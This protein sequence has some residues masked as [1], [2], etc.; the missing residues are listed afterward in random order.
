MKNCKKLFSSVLLVSFGALFMNDAYAYDNEVGKS[1]STYYWKI[2]GTQAG[3]SS[4][5]TTAINSCMGSNREVHVVTGG[6][7]NGTIVVPATNVKLYCHDNTFTRDFSGWGIK[8]RH[9]GFQVHDMILRGG[10]NGYGIRSDGGSHIKMI[11]VQIYDCPWIGIRVDSKENNPWEAWVTDLEIQ[12]VRVEDCGDQGIETYSI[13][14][15]VMDS[16]VV[17]NCTSCGVL[18]NLT[19]NGTIGTVNAY[20]CA[21]GSGYA[22]LRYA[23][24]C[25]NITTDK[26]IADH[27]GRG[28]FIVK[29]G[30][31]VNCHL[32][33]AEIYEC[34]DLGIW[35]E[36]GTNC[37]VKA[38]CCESPVSVSG[39]G[40]SVNVSRD[41]DRVGVTCSRFFYRSLSQSDDYSVYSID[42][43]FM[44]TIRFDRDKTDDQ[45]LSLPSGIYFIKS[46]RSSGS[47][48]IV[49]GS[50]R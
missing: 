2:N 5:L 46:R 33:N 20:N 37:S 17:R 44:P 45:Y 28:F 10:T 24:E 3:T 39:P 13:D 29:S 38:G 4:S 15:V 14:G 27:C 41:C 32:N 12:N 30:P 23:N 18:F 47:R 6:S 11:N 50:Y 42:G 25:T 16:I 9:D 8:N 31:S 7:L 40:S 34:S 19:K 49:V 1:G 36:N 26:L 22:G 35:I 43:K 21:W 48:K